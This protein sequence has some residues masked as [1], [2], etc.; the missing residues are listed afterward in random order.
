MDHRRDEDDSS[1][2]CGSETVQQK[3]ISPSP[4]STTS[5]AWNMLLS[6][7][8]Q[9]DHHQSSSSILPASSTGGKSG[10]SSSRGPRIPPTFKF[11]TSTLSFLYSCDLRL[12][13]ARVVPM[14]KSFCLR[15]SPETMQFVHRQAQ[16]AT[17]SILDTAFLFVER[18]GH[19]ATTDQQQTC[20]V[21]AYCLS[22]PDW[23][24][25]ISQLPPPSYE[26]IKANAL[27][28]AI[29]DEEEVRRAFEAFKA[30]PVARMVCELECSVEKQQ[31]NALSVCA[32]AISSSLSS[33]GEG[34]EVDPAAQL[35]EM[36]MQDPYFVCGKDSR[37]VVFVLSFS[38]AH[39]VCV[40]T[41]PLIL[42]A[43]VFAKRRRAVYSMDCTVATYAERFDQSSSGGG[44]WMGQM[45]LES[46]VNIPFNRC[47]VPVEA[48]DLRMLLTHCMLR[49]R[50]RTLKVIF[51]M[52]YFACSGSASEHRR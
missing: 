52:K 13:E 19:N 42:Y 40:C 17:T 38:A 18:R 15:V 34:E 21:D 25:Q 9:Q 24:N 6:I 23:N 46:V 27:M 51:D 35:R 20:N 11:V 22:H 48:I 28:R 14:E 3:E 49:Q 1:A 41:K 37:H 29:E 50:I 32:A 30:C 16:A 43:C 33:G 45:M 44:R 7:Q 26:E 12:L 36:L 31:G 39:C 2:A 10:S 8:Q 47:A 5:L 4:T